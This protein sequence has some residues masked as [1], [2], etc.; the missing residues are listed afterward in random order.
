MVDAFAGGAGTRRSKRDV[1]VGRQ[2]ARLFGGGRHR[3]V[4]TSRRAFRPHR[5]DLSPPS[6]KLRAAGEGA[7]RPA[8]LAQPVWTPAATLGS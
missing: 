8:S 5:H 1:A 7:Q 4:A 2:L 6:A 3:P